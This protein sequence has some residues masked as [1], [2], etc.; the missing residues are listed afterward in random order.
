MSLN[1]RPACPVDL[2]VAQQGSA[3][4]ARRVLDGDRARG[5][6]RTDGSEGGSG[7]GHGEDYGGEGTERGVRCRAGWSISFWGLV[8]PVSD[9]RC[10]VVFMR[11]LCTESM[12]GG[13]PHRRRCHSTMRCTIPSP[14]ST[15][16]EDPTLRDLPSGWLAASLA[17]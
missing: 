3:R 14:S 4:V 5:R 12:G 10:R 8:L 9:G 17:R 6:V 11:V 7:E 15:S 2:H 16:N 1:G 13:C